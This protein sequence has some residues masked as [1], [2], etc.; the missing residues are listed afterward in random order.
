MII[1]VKT[2]ICYNEGNFK[3]SKHLKL[4]M[5]RFL[6]ICCDQVSKSQRFFVVYEYR[7]IA[8]EEIYLKKNAFC[9]FVCPLGK[10]NHTVG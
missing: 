10:P 6:H 7:I 1:V 9:L 5:L 3:Q 2:L 4:H 8:F